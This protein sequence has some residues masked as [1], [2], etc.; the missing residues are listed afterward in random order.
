MKNFLI[1]IFVFFS[2]IIF[3]QREF[4]I[5]LGGGFHGDTCL[6]IGSYFENEKYVIDTLVNSEV[7]ESGLVVGLAKSIKVKYPKKGEY[8]ISCT[9]NKKHYLFRLDKICNKTEIRIELYDGIDFCV[10]Y[11]GGFKFY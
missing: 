4:K 3:S 7:L 1:I 5:L 9:V 11:R 6:I 10:K 2:N 8:S